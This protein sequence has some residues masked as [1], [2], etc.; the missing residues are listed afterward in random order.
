MDYYGKIARSKLTLKRD[1]LEKLHGVFLLVPEDGFVDVSGVCDGP[2]DGFEG[3]FCPELVG[4]GVTAT[5]GGTDGVAVGVLDANN[6]GNAVGTGVGL[7]VGNP[8]GTGVGLSVGN[9]V[10]TGVGLSVGSL[11][12]TGVGLSESCHGYR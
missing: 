2:G 12:G 11:V 3:R 1:A 4:P 6:E 10:G 8:V 5:A 9:P 7:S